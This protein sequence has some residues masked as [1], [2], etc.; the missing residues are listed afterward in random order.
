[1]RRLA[2]SFVFLGLFALIWPAGAQQ[3]IVTEIMQ[4][5][6]AVS[7]GSGEW[8]EVYNPG[9]SPVNIDGWTI[10]DD[11][12]NSHVISND[13]PLEVPAFGYFV[14]G[15]NADFG[16]NGG[17]NVD[18]QYS[19]FT[20]GNSDDE[21]ILEDGDGVEIDRVE[22]DNGAT[23]PDPNGSSM[24]LI[25]V[26]ADNN[27]GSAW[28]VGISVYGDGDH[29]T[30]GAA[31]DEPQF[32]EIMNPGFEEWA[33]FAD[34]PGFD[35]PDFWS[36]VGGT[37]NI[38][39]ETLDSHEG[40]SSA[41]LTIYDSGSSGGMYEK[42][43]GLA[44]GSPY[45]LGVWVIDNNASY[46]MLAKMT[47]YD[48]DDILL[49]SFTGTP[50]SDSPDWQ[51]VAVTA[52]IPAGTVYTKVSIK[53]SYVSGDGTG[54]EYWVDEFTL[55]VAR[56][57]EL[58]NGGFELWTEN[59][60]DGPPDGWTLDG[61]PA[62][63]T[64]SQESD[65]VFIGDHAAQ[66]A[67]A[68]P[69]S[70]SQTFYP[71][72][73]PDT[74]TFGG[75]V[76]QY[77]GGSIALSID[78]LDADD[79][80]LAGGTGDFSLFRNEWVYL[81]HD[82][83][84]PVGADHV[85]V[86]VNFYGSARQ[87]L[88]D[89]FE[90]GVHYTEM[91]I[92]QIQTAAS[93]D[94][95]VQFTG[96]VTQGN[97]T[98]DGN[99]TRIYVQDA[100]GYGIN[101]FDF[102]ELAGD[103]LVRG[104]EVW[105]R[106]TVDQYY[107]VTE[108]VD[109]DY[110]V[111]SEGDGVTP[112][113][114]PIVYDSTAGFVMAAAAME[115]SWAQVS[116]EVTGTSH[117][118]SGTNYELDDGSGVAV[119]RIPDDAAFD[120]ASLL[121]VGAIATVRGVIVPYSGTPQLQPSDISDIEAEMHYTEL[122]NGDFESWEDANTPAVWTV[123]PLGSGNSSVM[124]EDT[125]VH[126][127]EYSLKAVINEWNGLQLIENVYDVTEG[128]DYEFSAW[129]KFNGSDELTYVN[130]NL[131]FYDVDDTYLEDYSS[132]VSDAD[133]WSQL[134]VQG[135]APA[136]SAFA[137]LTIFL[138]GDDLNFTGP[139]TFYVDDAAFGVVIDPNVLANTGF[140]SWTD[141]LPDGWS[142]DA[143][144]GG[145]IL[146][147]ET[148]EVHDGASAARVSWTSDQD[149]V[150]LSQTITDG[151]IE[152][153]WWTLNGYCKVS[154]PSAVVEFAVTYLDD[155]DPIA[156]FIST[157]NP[158]GISNY[159]WMQAMTEVPPWAV[160]A[161]AEIRFRADAD[162]DGDATA[163]VDDIRFEP[164]D[165]EP[166]ETT[167]EALQTRTIAENTIVSVEGDVVQE[168]GTTAPW[169]DNY[170]FDESSGYGILCYHDEPYVDVSAWARGNLVQVIGEYSVYTSGPR[171]FDEI[172]NY[173][174]RV[175]EEGIG[176]PDPLLFTT[177]DFAS[178][179][180]EEGA[181]AE[182][183]GTLQSEP[184]TNTG[185]RIND[186]SGADAEFIVWSS[187]GIDLSS[188]HRFDVVTVRGTI[189]LYYDGSVIHVQLQ[190][191]MPG[192]VIAG[193]PLDSPGGLEAFY[194]EDGFTVDLDWTF[195]TDDD[196]YLHTGVYRNG[197]LI[198]TT[199]DDS[200]TD[201]LDDFGTFTYMV[202]AYYYEGP[203]APSASVEIEAP[204]PLWAPEEFDAELDSATGEVT[205]SWD[206]V[207]GFG[208]G[209]ERIEVV[210]EEDLDG[211]WLYTGSVM[212][213]RLTTAAPAQVLQVQYF[214]SISAGPQMFN[215]S[216]WNWDADAGTPGIDLMHSGTASGASDG[217]VAVDVADEGIVVD[218]DFVVGF[219][220]VD[221]S[222]A[223]G[224]ASDIHGFSWNYVGMSSWEVQPIMT[225]L[226]RAVVEYTDGTVDMVTPQGLEPVLTASEVM[227]EPVRLPVNPRELDDTEDFLEYVLSRDGE[228]IAAVDEVEYTDELP[229][230]GEYEYSLIAR[231]DE[232]DS[233]PVTLTVNWVDTAVDE[234][235]WS[236]IPTEFAISA[237]YPNPFNPSVQV[238]LAVPVADVLRAEVYDI[239]GR[240]VVTLVSRRLTPGYHRMVWQP[241]SLPSGVYFLKVHATE[242]GWTD[243][244][245][246]MFLK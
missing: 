147:E 114:D 32:T 155:G 121:Q 36:S 8:F 15:V 60:A 196:S 200:Y 134:I 120:H 228:E 25:N 182:I 240:R 75:W 177:D 146:E 197:V 218:G 70:M 145:A 14:L 100:T 208:D 193:S 210:D 68:D 89:E 82:E 136:G 104:D 53:L 9:S 72:S 73:F 244:H 178:A 38:A 188:F 20:L 56:Q 217:W 103:S 205:L 180:D 148:T 21:V 24:S 118:G 227:S 170:I 27:V 91:T 93:V 26:N 12:S 226:I 5:P 2:R 131:A 230:F 214:T 199:T 171:E 115:G 77:D 220:N 221:P 125:E 88:L 35:E 66:A 149:V 90:F 41:K 117:T 229:D 13:G 150:T 95:L 54:T 80:W 157:P 84:V 142:F 219:E 67:W 59:G 62:G 105:V 143:G 183:T 137:R 4:N 69:V 231:Y 163:L 172:L 10:R 138:Y 225:Y 109:F 43:Y 135:E 161:V 165:E 153:D 101:L 140:E 61:Q 47:F 181:W 3:V 85:I 98:V 213:T 16:T 164:M 245:K 243:L 79:T 11:G 204:H 232:G 112:P 94:D 65:T 128:T 173:T 51:R 34:N 192:D 159:T 107:D 19:G 42:I 83:A 6:S 160:S 195:D 111:L 166:V 174:Y 236:G 102:S 78:I 1:M 129:V 29:G 133:E 201:F 87:A 46:E 222:V 235:P 132:N 224:G 185:I 184:G 168:P 190:P 216:L 167:L 215:T 108:V 50:S 191:S 179:V 57:T 241:E 206:E 237:A 242:S 203:S 175:L 99:D 74:V 119:V 45:E 207:S 154:D 106:G 141:G 113:F 55:G 30:P 186:G 64:V 116:G 76:Y 23:F 97:L 49:D 189:D 71:E 151:L 92:E 162:W 40:G 144:A 233:D 31:N 209:V 110:I 169:N 198:G 211:Y 81:S 7:D 238:V 187:T 139:G 176:L 48:A 96:H 33:W 246:L 123:N 194:D 44:E 127:G 124:Q 28:M 202:R 18:Y 212:A 152:G 156:T 86:T 223:L 239:L 39:E 158:D 122:Q 234:Q 126:G 58:L 130:V 22:Y 17:V 37:F 52:T 63:F